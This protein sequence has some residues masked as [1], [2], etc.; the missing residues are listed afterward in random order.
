M[1]SA[2]KKRKLEGR[3]KKVKKKRKET[4]PEDEDD[5]EILS[6]DLD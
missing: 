1:I 4:V 5:E 2:S 3:V 6:D